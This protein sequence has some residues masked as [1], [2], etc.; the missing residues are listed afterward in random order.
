MCNCGTRQKYESECRTY[1]RANRED[2]NAE[3]APE[4]LVYA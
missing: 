1:A 3:F 2:N 4:L